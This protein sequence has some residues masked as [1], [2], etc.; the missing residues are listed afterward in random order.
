MKPDGD[1]DTDNKLSLDDVLEGERGAIS[2]FV[3]KE[4]L[5]EDND[6]PAQPATDEDGSQISSDHQLFDSASDIDSHERYDEGD[7]GAVGTGE[8]DNLLPHQ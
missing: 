1:D 7:V 3:G 6:T 5:P 8:D 4:K 2:W